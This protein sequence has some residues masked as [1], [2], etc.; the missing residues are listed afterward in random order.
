MA[1]L[2]C[3]FKL[4]SLQWAVGEGDHV[5]RECNAVDVLA[6]KISSSIGDSLLLKMIRVRNE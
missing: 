5:E 4:F 1:R 2:E 6:L 3:K